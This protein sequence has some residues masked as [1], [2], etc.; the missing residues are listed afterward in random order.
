MAA[1]LAD[2]IA[3]ARQSTPPHNRT[4]MDGAPASCL[5]H[6]LQPQAGSWEN[7]GNTGVVFIYGTVMQGGEV[8]GW[9]NMNT[10]LGDYG[11][12]RR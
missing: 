5:P 1:S 4:P 6:L 9:S 8:I 2:H 12:W 7:A 11:G 10:R 3:G